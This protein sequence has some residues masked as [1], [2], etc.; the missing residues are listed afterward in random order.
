MKQWQLDLIWLL[1]IVATVAAICFLFHVLLAVHVLAAPWH[2]VE[3]H[4]GTVNESGPYYGFWSGFGANFGELAII[5]GVYAVIRKHNCHVK[6]CRAL[7]THQVVGTPYIACNKHHPHLKEDEDITAE[8]IAKA[9]AAA[10]AR[11]LR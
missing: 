10:R 3:V 11:E 2:W 6:G 7:R 8:E 5:T 9:A 4:T 1:G